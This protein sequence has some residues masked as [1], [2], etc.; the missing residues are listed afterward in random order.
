MIGCWSHFPCLP[1]LLLF[2]PTAYWKVLCSI[3]VIKFGYFPPPSISVCLVFDGIRVWT[4]GFVLTRQV[5]YH[6]NHLQSFCSGYLWD[7][8]SLL[9]LDKPGLWSSYL[10]FLLKLE[11]QCVLP[12]PPFSVEMESWKLFCLGWPRSAILLISASSVAGITD[13]SHCTWS[14]N[15]FKFLYMRP[16]RM[17]FLSYNFF[18]Q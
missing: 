13:M 4:Q 17:S 10:C 18:C 2:T 5:L 3:L 16:H 1:G 6:L 15:I 7:R 14:L 11:F 8:V 12:H 9:C